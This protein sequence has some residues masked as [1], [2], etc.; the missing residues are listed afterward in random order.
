MIS[1][2]K[3]GLRAIPVFERQEDYVPIELTCKSLCL[4]YV[5]LGSNSIYRFFPFV[6]RNSSPIGSRARKGL[7]A[8]SFKVHRYLPRSIGIFAFLLGPNWKCE[9]AH[10]FCRWQS[11]CAWMQQQ[12]GANVAPPIG[13]TKYPIANTPKAASSS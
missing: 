10:E 9:L 5:V 11:G 4:L 3:T 13:L 6:A 2:D 7:V 8:L 12:P 1:R